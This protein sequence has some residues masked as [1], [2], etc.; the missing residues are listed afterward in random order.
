MLDV[1][2]LYD[3]K[4]EFCRSQLLSCEMVGVVSKVQ[5]PL[6]SAVVGVYRKAIPFEVPAKEKYRRYDC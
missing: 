2:T 5:Y 1:S 3:D 4:A 6:E